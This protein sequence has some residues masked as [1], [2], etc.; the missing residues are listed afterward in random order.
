[1]SLAIALYFAAAA[2]QPGLAEAAE[3]QLRGA[4]VADAR[5][6]V[7]IMRAAVLRDG[8]IVFNDGKQGPR[9]QELRREGRV[10]YEF[11]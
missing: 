3:P 9:T 11:E 5:I 6:A 8:V 2:A 4:Q 1:M 10:T 7:Q